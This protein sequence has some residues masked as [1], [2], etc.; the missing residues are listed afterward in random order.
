M[1]TYADLRT[2]VYA[3]TRLV[4][5]IKHALALTIGSCVGAHTKDTWRETRTVVLPDMQGLGVGTCLLFYCRRI[6]VT[7]IHQ[8]N[9][10]RP[11]CKALVQL[12]ASIY[13]LHFKQ[14]LLGSS[15]L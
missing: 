5:G 14:I 4:T 12:H 10:G 8:T 3:L 9:L 1:L 11:T 2:P 7:T 15:P 13:S 6:Y